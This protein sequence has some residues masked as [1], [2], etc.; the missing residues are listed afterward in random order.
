MK[1]NVRNNDIAV[2]TNILEIDVPDALRRRI[3]TGVKFFD[4][5]L[6]GEGLTPSAVYLFTGTPGSGKTTM[7]LTLANN[8]TRK[9]AVAMFNTAE[10][11]LYQIRMTAER[12][13]LRSG[14]VAGQ[15]TNVPQ[16][17]ENC[18]KVR[19]ANPGKDFVLIV[20]SLQCMEDGKFQTGRI[21]TATAERSLQ[22]ITDYCKAHMVNAIIIGQV[23]KG[24]QMAGSNKLKHMVDAKLALDVERKDQDL[25]GCR[26][27]T[28]EKNR[29]GGAG[30]IFYLNLRANGFQEVARVSVG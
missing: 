13:K 16:L 7:M 6:G 23:T 30:H 2:G 20:D 5:A 18:D 19:A 24:G 28:T 21:T 14:F 8:L 22:M 11:S 15:E 27:L 9:G 26:V 10:E 1:L 4:D 3:P 25:F 17:L 29:F 12:L